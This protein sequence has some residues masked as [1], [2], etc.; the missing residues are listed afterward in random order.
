MFEEYLQKCRDKMMESLESLNR[1]I[2]SISTGRANPKLLDSVKVEVYGS[3]MPLNQLSTVSVPD[4]TTL[5]VQVWDNSNI[6]ATEKAIIDANLGFSPTVDGAV[7]RINIPTL[8]EERR[9]ELSK[10]AKKYGEDKKVSIRNIRRDI[11]DSFKKDNES[12]GKD[13]IH[14]FGDLVQKITDEYIEKINEIISK[15]EKEIM[16]V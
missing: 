12:G 6:R 9:Q 10:L 4:A 3:F 7:L 11:I 14:A 16:T 15:K 8:S 13:D 2:E 1:D 5:S